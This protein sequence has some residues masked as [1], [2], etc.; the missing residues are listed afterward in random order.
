LEGQGTHPGALENFV[1]GFACAVEKI[2][3]YFHDGRGTFLSPI[4]EDR[5]LL[6]V[7]DAGRVLLGLFFWIQVQLKLDEKGWDGA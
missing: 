7:T 2:L 4:A 6:L 5:R 3:D 1:E